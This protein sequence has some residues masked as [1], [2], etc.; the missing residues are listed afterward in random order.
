MKDHA[1]L[2]WLQNLKDPEGRLARWVLKLQ[3]Y[4][5]E[6]LYRL[7]SK[8]QNADGLS[9][10]PNIAVLADIVDQLFDKMISGKY[11]DKPETV[12]QVLEKLLENTKIYNWQLIK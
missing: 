3:A 4:N 9:R 10:L 7:G 12:R 5:F 1:S 8:H 6:I 2:S 11:Q